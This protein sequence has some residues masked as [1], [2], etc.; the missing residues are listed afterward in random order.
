MRITTQML[1]ESAKKTGIPLNQKT[2]LNYIN[3][4]GNHS[5]TLLNALHTNTLNTGNRTKYEKQEKAADELHTQVQKFLAEGENSIFGQAEAS[6]DTTKLGGEAE[7]LVKTYNSL[8]SVLSKSADSMD[9]F[10]KQSLKDSASENKE[11]LGSAGITIKN[12]GSLALDAD[13]FSAASLDSIRKVLGKES[14]FITKLSFLSG[15]I[16]DY[17]D[18]NLESISNNYLSGKTAING[19]MSRYDVRG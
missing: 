18:S 4:D 14:S 17:A 6:D 11:M 8:L 16:G 9:A 5:D 12:D 1:Q 13:K 2:L 3:N 19:R 7:A 15:R 10:Y